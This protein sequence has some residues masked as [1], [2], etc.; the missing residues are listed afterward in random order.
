MATQGLGTSLG[1][2]PHG[3]STRTPNHFRAMG[4]SWTQSSILHLYTYKIAMRK[5]PRLMADNSQNGESN[6]KEKKNKDMMI[7]TDTWV[8][9]KPQW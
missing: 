9:K 3:T 1:F 8:K 7:P 5:S 2:S 4:S 6:G